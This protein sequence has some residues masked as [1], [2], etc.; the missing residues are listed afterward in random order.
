MT[1]IFYT[2]A[3]FLLRCHFNY[4]SFMVETA[5]QPLHPQSLFPKIEFH[6]EF[7]YDP[8]VTRISATPSGS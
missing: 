6:C 4:Q 3:S 8:E 1:D 2:A 5:T 7:V